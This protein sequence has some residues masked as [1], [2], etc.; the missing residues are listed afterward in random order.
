MRFVVV[1]LLLKVLADWFLL[2]PVESD[3]KGLVLHVA[4]GCVER[5]EHELVGSSKFG[6]QLWILSKLVLEQ[7]SQAH[8]LHRLVECLPEL[9]NGA[10]LTR[11]DVRLSRFSGSTSNVRGVGAVFWS[12]FV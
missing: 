6:S 2:R 12:Y 11:I 1:K 4:N 5:V 10:Q 8:L 3:A 7:D 9:L